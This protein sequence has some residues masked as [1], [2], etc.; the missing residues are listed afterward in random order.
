[1]IPITDLEKQYFKDL[2]TFLR[3]SFNGAGFDQL[4]QK[5]N[6]ARP[7]DINF[8]NFLINLTNKLSN[9]I[10]KNVDSLI[11]LLIILKLDKHELTQDEWD[12]INNL[13][14]HSSNLIL[15]IHSFLEIFQ[16]LKNQK[17][18]INTRKALNSTFREFV[19]NLELF[20][21]KL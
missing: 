20:I 19:K 17:E 13:E 21:W 10:S 5:F 2:A 4:P 7:N 18:L 11:S 12:I 1:M 3:T 14:W 9:P 6:E 15:Q 16:D 8:N